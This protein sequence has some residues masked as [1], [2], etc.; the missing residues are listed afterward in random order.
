[1]NKGGIILSDNVLWSGKVL[2]PLHERR[3]HQNTIGIQRFTKK[4]PKGRN[5]F[6]TWDGLTV[7]ST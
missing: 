7:S 6:I 2:E 4:W 3:K 1:M 5:R